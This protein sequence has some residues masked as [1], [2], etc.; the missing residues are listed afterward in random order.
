M[1]EMCQMNFL[2][3]QKKHR[4]SVVIKR[5]RSRKGWWVKQRSSDWWNRIVQ[6]HFTE[7]DW[8]SNF[9]MTSNT[10]KYICNRLR[11]HLLP[12]ENYVRQPLKKVAIAIY[13]FASC[14]EYRVIANQFGTNKCV[15]HKCI[16]DFCKAM[17]KEFSKEIPTMPNEIEAQEIAFKFEEICGIPNVIGAIDGTHIPILAPTNGHS[18]FINRK[19]WTSY[20]VLAVI[21][22]LYR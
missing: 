4:N 1:Q 14:A 13:K 20:N 22:N 5:K 17:C 6:K 8:L 3:F 2:Y 19:G 11:P 10:F 15:V 16:Y 21:D 7:E 18:D 9:R 12:K